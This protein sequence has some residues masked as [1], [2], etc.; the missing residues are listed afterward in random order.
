M[1][2]REAA[3]GIEEGHADMR[4]LVEWVLQRLD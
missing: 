4:A 2:T 3:T 1:L